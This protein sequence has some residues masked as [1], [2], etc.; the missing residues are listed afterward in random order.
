MYINIYIYIYM[1]IHLYV[2][3]HV[4][5]FPYVY[6]YIYIYVYIFIYL[7]I[8][9][10]V[11]TFGPSGGAGGHELTHIVLGPCPGNRGGTHHHPPFKMH[12]GWYFQLH[13]F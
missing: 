13:S 11:F 5:P 1:Y 7:H 10:R 12:A 3:I 8:N 6:M 2:Y 9:R 4:Y